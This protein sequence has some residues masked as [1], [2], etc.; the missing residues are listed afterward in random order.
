MNS[1]KRVYQCINCNGQYDLRKSLKCPHCGH[2][3]GTK[4][5]ALEERL[6]AWGNY[7]FN[8]PRK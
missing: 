1:K 4:A 2:K 7:T 6:I 8:N 3:L 5:K